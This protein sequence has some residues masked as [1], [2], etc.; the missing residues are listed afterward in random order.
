MIAISANVASN[1][2]LWAVQRNGTTSP[3]V[4]F[5]YDATNLAH[6][7]YNSNQTGQRDHFGG[8]VKFTTAVVTNGHVYAGSEYTFSLFG[9]FPAST[10]APQAPTGLTAT[11]VPDT[12]I[13]LAWTNPTPG[14]NNA[15]T[16]LKVFRPVGDH[17]QEWKDSLDRARRGG[18]HVQPMFKYAQDVSVSPGDGRLAR[19]RVLPRR[20]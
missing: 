20:V 4:L 10:Q 14:P 16:G 12:Q 1:G 13:R 3:G 8:S 18:K 15:A 2:I 9:L 6:E 17:L 5:A 11:G 7:L 19:R